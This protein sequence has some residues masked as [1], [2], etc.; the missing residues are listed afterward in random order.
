MVAFAENLV[1]VTFVAFGN[2]APDIFGAL[3]ALDGARP[4]P[5]LAFGALFGA[6]IFVTTVVVGAIAVIKPFPPMQRPL[7][8]DVIFYLAV[9]AWAY[10][11]LYRSAVSIF[12][13]GNWQSRRQCDASHFPFQPPVVIA[14]LPNADVSI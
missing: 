13:A 4:Q 5:G 7:L 9:V 14:S 10:S 2:G 11:I 1:G 3:A 8:R 6:G 12:D